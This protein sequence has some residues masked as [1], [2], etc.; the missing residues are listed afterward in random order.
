M[1]F[2]AHTTEDDEGRTLYALMDGCQT[3]KKPPI[4]DLAEEQ[5]GWQPLSTHLVNVANAARDFAK[6]FGF[7]DEAHRAGLLHDL[8]KYG[9]AFSFGCEARDQASIIGRL[10]H[11]KHIEPKRKPAPL[12]LMAITKAFRLLP[13]CKSFSKLTSNAAT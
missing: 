5:I 13:N 2:Y 10:A 1:N 8:G 4:V 9:H 7:G 6:P 11:S 3:T 12:P